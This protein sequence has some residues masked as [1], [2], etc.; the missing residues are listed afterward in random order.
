MTKVSV[1]VPAFSA[2]VHLGLGIVI[3]GFV[4]PTWEFRYSSAY[5]SQLLGYSN[6]YLLHAIK[7]G[8]KKLKALKDKGFTG[9]QIRVR[10]NRSTRGSARP[11]TISFDDFCI[12]VEYEAFDLNNPKAQ[13]LLSASF[14]EVLRSRTQEAFQEV[15]GIVPDSLEKRIVQFQFNYSSYLQYEESRKEDYEDIADLELYGDCSSLD[16][17]VFQIYAEDFLHLNYEG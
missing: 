5:V 17:K 6:N 7:K 2:T 13:A 14:R 1:L 11:Y 8:T 9:D 4:L 16:D 15:T 10:G 3:E 12:W